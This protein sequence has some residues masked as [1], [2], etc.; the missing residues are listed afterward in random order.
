MENLFE[1]YRKVW[2]KFFNCSDTV[3][4]SNILSQIKL[5]FTIPVSNRHLKKCFSQ[6]K[7]LKTDQRSS[8]NEERLHNLLRIWLGR[9]T[10]N[11]MG[12]K[13]AVKLWWDDKT[14]RTNRS[15]HTVMYNTHF[16]RKHYMYTFL[17]VIYVQCMFFTSFINII[18]K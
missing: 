12:C 17:Q 7:I 15:T 4:W 3:R 1:N 6:I 14:H 16:Y 18:I 13:I 11:P 9:A 5:L 2:W 10:S 8:L